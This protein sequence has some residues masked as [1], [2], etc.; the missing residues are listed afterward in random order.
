MKKLRMKYIFFSSNIV[1][2]LDSEIYD[3]NTQFH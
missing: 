1:S 2:H 3:Y